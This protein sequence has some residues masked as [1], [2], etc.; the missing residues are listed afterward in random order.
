M[1][2]F[3]SS[4]IDDL[5]RAELAGVWLDRSSTAAP[6]L[7][8]I[9]KLPMNAIR[10]VYAGAAVSLCAWVIEI[11]GKH[12]AAFGLRVDDNPQHQTLFY[13][14]CRSPEEVEDLGRLLVAGSFPLQIHNE[15]FLPLLYAACRVAPELAR[16]VVQL[17]PSVSYPADDGFQLRARALDVLRD[18]KSIPDQRMKAS[19][20][21]PIR[22]KQTQSLKAHVA[23]SGTVNLDD[24]NEGN[25]LERLAFQAFDALFPFGAFHGPEVQDGKARR[26]LCDILAVSRVREHNNEGIFLVESKVSSAT[27]EGLKRTGLRRGASIRKN[28]MKGIGQLKGAIGKLRDGETI[29]RQD[30]TS[31][32]VDL[33]IPEVKEAVEPLNLHER[34]RQIG[35]AIVLVSDMH[36]DIDWVELWQHLLDACRETEYFFHVLDLRELGRLVTHSKVRPALFEGF[37]VQRWKVMAERKTA[38]VRFQFQT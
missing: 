38:L 29:F 20:V 15:N 28:I 16:P 14:G 31:I 13:G 19:C 24:D 6:D 18:S 33:P 7:W 12:I 8:M 25:E 34:A 3:H 11:E 37:L 4:R 17:L 10:S 23:D 26:E 35:T 2:Y 27:A 30:G 1:L 21:L 36:E 5:M 32:E 9:A 22:F